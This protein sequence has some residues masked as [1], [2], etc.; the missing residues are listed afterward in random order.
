MP[1]PPVHKPVVVRPESYKTSYIL[2][3]VVAFASLAITLVIG[4]GAIYGLSIQTITTLG[5]VGSLLTFAASLLPRVTKPPSDN[6]K[7]LD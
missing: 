4:A 2:A 3:V 7:G 5:I 1:T 6:R